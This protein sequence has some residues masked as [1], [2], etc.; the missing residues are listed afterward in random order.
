M[1][2]SMKL[3][4]TVILVLILTAIVFGGYVIYEKMT[5]VTAV[6]PL[7]TLTTIEGETFNLS[8][9]RSKVVIL[10]FMTISCRPCRDLISTLKEVY[11][12]Y[13]DV[14]IISICIDATESDKDIK[15]F[16]N[17]LGA[18]WLFAKDTEKVSEKYNVLFI[19]KTVLINPKGELTF[20]HSGSISYT[21]L[22]Q[23]IEYAK[24]GGTVTVVNLALPLM[25]FIAGILAFFSPCSFPLLPGYIAYYLS[26]KEAHRNKIFHGLQAALGIIVFYLFIGILGVVCSEIIKQFI[27]MFELIIGI[28]IIILG[29]MLLLHI[30]IFTTSSQMLTTKLTT[31]TKKI[32]KL[33]LF[34]YGIIYGAASVGCT[35]PVFLLIIFLAIYSE[36][37]LYG[38]FVIMLYAIGMAVFMIIVTVLVATAKNAI[39]RKLK[40]I[41]KYI[42]TICGLILLLVGI[43]LVINAI[44][45]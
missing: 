25:A 4:I 7:F 37:L 28:I 34:F 13:P 6:A 39:I 2:N 29:L 23:K 26:R 8:D 9:F 38:I 15:D 40:Q 19:P 42:N 11:D 20:E 43:Y 12:E 30:P 14:V 5:M 35:L 3:K 10:D 36:N 21:Q 22:K 16:K 1:L 41:P 17:D 27:P 32:N 33:G 44:N 18:D 45:L 31:V 24:Y